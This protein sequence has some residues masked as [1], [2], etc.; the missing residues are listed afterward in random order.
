MNENCLKLNVDKSE[1]IITGSRQQLLKCHKQTINL[2]N[3]VIPINNIMKYQ[4]VLIYSSLTFKKQIQAKCRMAM[5][6][7]LRIKRIR[8]LLTGDACHTLARG[9]ELS[10]L[11]FCNAMYVGLPNTD[12][13]KLQRVQN[14]AGKLVNN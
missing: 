3:N 4:G 9:L 6:N 11:D 5:F 7:L 8:H 12:I 13:Q 10:H 2:D 1:V 14:S